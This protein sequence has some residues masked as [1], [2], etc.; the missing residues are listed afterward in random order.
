MD[1]Y[2]DNLKQ[3]KIFNSFIPKSFKNIQISP[4]VLHCILGLIASQGLQSPVKGIVINDTAGASAAKSLGASFSAVTEIVTGSSICSGSLIADNYVLTAQHCLSSTDPKGVSVKF[5]DENNNTLANISVSQILVLDG[6]DTFDESR[7]FDGTDIAILELAEAA[8]KSIT[9][10]KLFGS[11]PENLIGSNASI[12]GF[13]LNGLG[14]TGHKGTRDKLRWG[15]E[16]VIDLVGSV[17]SYFDAIFQSN[18]LN[19]DFDDGTNDSNTLTDTYS[20]TTPLY[21]EGTTALGDSGGPLLVKIDDELLIAGVLSDGSTNTSQFGDISSFTGITEHREFIENFGGE[22]VGSFEPETNPTDDIQNGSF[23]TGN[24]NFKEA[25]TGWNTIGAVGIPNSTF[26]TL[27][28]DGDTQALMVNDKFLGTAD[29]NEIEQFLGLTSESLNNLSKS[30]T[31]GGSAMKQT[32]TANAGDII[33]FDF[34]FLTSESTP[35]NAKNDFSFVSFASNVLDNPFLHLLSDTFSNFVNSNTRFSRETGYESFE[36]EILETGDYT[37]GFGVAN[38]T[39]DAGHSGLLV[40]NIKVISSVSVPE[41]N[42]T[43]GLFVSALF[44]VFSFP[45]KRKS[46]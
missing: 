11:N 15:A 41:P 45:K 5:N 38:A 46:K 2:F 40:D 37:L 32:F 34:N 14:S 27:P 3:Q 17:D 8:P 29:A 43:F 7:L 26:G 20:Q 39:T 1:I 16:N 24:G 25:L 6:D 35:N 33:S 44:G 21:N 10:L 13:G 9:P 28:S 31:F 4:I 18:I 42:I 12:V 22:F 30:N 36:Y 23:E 19:L